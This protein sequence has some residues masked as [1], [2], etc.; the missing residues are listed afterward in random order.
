[1]LLDGLARGGQLGVQDFLRVMLDP[2]VAWI[3]LAGFLLSLGEDAAVGRHYEASGA[4]GAL[5]ECKNECHAGPADESKNSPQ[6]TG[7]RPALLVL[8]GAAPDS[9]GGKFR[10]KV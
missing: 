5:I 3:V 6:C 4:G 7:C 1:G 2:V 9:V 10:C 8:R